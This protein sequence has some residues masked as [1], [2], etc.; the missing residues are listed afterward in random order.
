MSSFISKDTKT[1][2][3]FDLAVAHE[4][5]EDGG[6]DEHTPKSRHVIGKLKSET[7]KINFHRSAP[8]II[9]RTIKLNGDEL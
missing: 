6:Q 4:N 1:L 3:D 8:I 2:A 9:V 5:F 7:E